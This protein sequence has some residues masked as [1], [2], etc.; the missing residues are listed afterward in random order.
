MGL[1]QREHVVLCL[2]A[3]TPGLIGRVLGWSE[4]EYQILISEARRELRDPTLH[5]YTQ[6]R[7]T[8]GRKPVS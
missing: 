4:T 2:E 8:Y 6:F 3:F 1:Y 7:F 5:L